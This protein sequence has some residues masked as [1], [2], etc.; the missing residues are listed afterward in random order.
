VDTFGTLAGIIPKL[1][2]G[3]AVDFYGG[4]KMIII[5]CIGVIAG[6]L[7]LP[8]GTS[9][10]WLI[11]MWSIV[12]IFGGIPW[13]SILKICSKWFRHYRLGVVMSL[14]SFSYLFGDSVAVAY[15]GTLSY[16]G[17]VDWK[18][19]FFISGFNLFIF[20]ITALLI[21]RGSPVAIG[22]TEADTFPANRLGLLGNKSRANEWKEVFVPIFVSPAFWVLALWYSGVYLLAQIFFNWTIPFLQ[23]DA[24]SDSAVSFGGLLLFNGFGA[25]SMLLFGVLTDKMS[26]FC[27]NMAVSLSLFCSIV[28]L[29]LL[30]VISQYTNLSV[31]IVLPVI[32]VCGFLLVGPLS[33]PAGVIAISFGG[34]R[35]CGTMSGTL[36]AFGSLASILAGPAGKWARDNDRWTD[37]WGYMAILAGVVTFL[38]LLYAF[39]DRREVNLCVLDDS[40]HPTRSIPSIA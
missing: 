34:K 27:R 10:W 1:F 26:T 20:M 12:C 29:T 28:S 7:A 16:L 35:A 30:A 13:P 31:G 14:M 9:L 22:F 21:L 23:S 37:L 32:S 18:A 39:L 11:S 5:G 33:L 19:L 15:I 6:C 40:N 25:I 8:I 17:V 38:S 36:D 2:F 3:A 24:F 4:K